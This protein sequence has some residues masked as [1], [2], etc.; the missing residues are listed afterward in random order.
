MN[1]TVKD[2]SAIGAAVSKWRDGSGLERLPVYLGWTLAVLYL[3]SG[4][5]L[6]SVSAFPQMLR[7][8]LFRAAASRYVWCIEDNT[9]EAGSMQELYYVFHGLKAVNIAAALG[10]I[11]LAVC[12]AV[13]CIRSIQL[14]KCAQVQLA[15]FF[16][17]RMIVT[18][19][20]AAAAS[21]V[22]RLDLFSLFGNAVAVDLI[23]D[24]A[25]IALSAYCCRIRKK[26]FPEERSSPNNMPDQ[27]GR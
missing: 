4:L 19:L 8:V 18:V 1:E 16:G 23:I 22:M 24:A 11:A 12:L 13:A 20:C 14:R 27:M 9:I 21:F 10:Q 26:S 7:K 25:M 2:N 15:A 17:I 3:A 5:K 6:M